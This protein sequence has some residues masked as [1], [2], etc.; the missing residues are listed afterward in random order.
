MG[1]NGGDMPVAMPD[2][3]QTMGGD[4]AQQMGG[5]CLPDPMTDGQTCG[6]GCSGGT[7]GVNFNGS[8]KCWYN[9][10]P[11]MVNSCPCGRTCASLC[12]PTDAG[13]I[14]TGEGACLP[15]NGAAE[16]CGNNPQNMPWHFGA[17]QDGTR[18]VNSDMNGTYAY[19][20]YSCTKSTDCPAGTSCLPLQG[21]GNVCGLPSAPGSPAAG[22]M[23]DGNGLC[24]PGV[25]CDKMNMCI[26]Q[27]DGPWD[28]TNC[29][30]GTTCKPIV[31][32]KNMKI[33]AYTCQ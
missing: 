16:R 21:G 9:C 6:N 29:A 11:K 24:A 19:C 28:M 32:P 15:A 12:T 4:M 3:S 27:C 17:C 8:C 31:D 25:V 30:N 5:N 20:L 33:F 7:R 23:C 2:L 18:C 14:D 22:M 10:T 13:C 26:A 1:S